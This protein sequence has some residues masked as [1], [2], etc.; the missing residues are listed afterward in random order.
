MR[1]DGSLYYEVMRVSRLL[2]DVTGDVTKGGFAIS[3]Q[4]MKGL[5]NFAEGSLSSLL[6]QLNVLMCDTTNSMTGTLVVSGAGGAASHLRKR[7][8]EA[9][10]GPDGEQGHILAE[11][12]D[13]LSHEE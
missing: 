10:H 6:W 1:V 3:A 5:E 13:C 8:E 9:T 7:I 4:L 12:R 11:Q 2:K